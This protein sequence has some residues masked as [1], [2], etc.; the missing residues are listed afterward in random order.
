M[1]PTILIVDYNLEQNF[2]LQDLSGLKDF[3]LINATDSWMGLKLAKAQKPDLIIW[4][5]NLIKKDGYGF[6]YKLKN[7]SNRARP[8]LIIMISDADKQEA[9]E[10]IKLEENVYLQKPIDLKTLC[11]TIGQTLVGHSQKQ[12]A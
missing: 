2:K 5:F 6:L 10:Q 7:G 1:K 9:G 8:P 4:D 3:N 12:L 11:R